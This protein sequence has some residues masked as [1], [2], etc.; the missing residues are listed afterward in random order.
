MAHGQSPRTLLKQDIAFVENIAV[1]LRE[2]CQRQEPAPRQIDL[3]PPVGLCGQ[4]PHLR[5]RGEIEG[6]QIKNVLTVG[7]IADTVI[8][9]VFGED[10]D[11]P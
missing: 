11:I 1:E 10:K 8:A 6:P 3:E 9:S 5:K 7:E 2:I 4:G